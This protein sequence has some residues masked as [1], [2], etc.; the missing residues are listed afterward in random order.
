M[1]VS[2]GKPIYFWGDRGQKKILYATAE[3]AEV[4]K[5]LEALRKITG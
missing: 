1:K 3:M 2:E 5:K 4:F